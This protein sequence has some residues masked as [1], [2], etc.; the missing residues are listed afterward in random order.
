MRQLPFPDCTFDV[1]RQSPVSKE[2]S[3][4]PEAN[5]HRDDP[6]RQSGPAR[7]A[8]P[9]GS[10]RN[11]ASEFPMVKLKSRTKS[12]LAAQMQTL[13]ARQSRKRID[14]LDQR[15]G[16]ME[17]RLDSMDANL[18]AVRERLVKVETKLEGGH[19]VLSR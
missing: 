3:H 9:A 13:I 5:H 17:T 14:G 2:S 10:R 8:S 6:E 15:M 18:A 19:V 12:L 16:R 11:S 1:Q 4:E 7:P